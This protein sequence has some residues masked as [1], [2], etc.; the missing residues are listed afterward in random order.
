M[1]V[2]LALLAA[3]AFIV[4]AI[5][6]SGSPELD[7]AKRFAAAWQ[8]GDYGAMYAELNAGLEVGNLRRRVRRRLREGR[9]TATLEADRG[10]RGPR[11]GQTST[12]TEQVAVE[13]QAA[14][15]SFG[16]I[17]GELAIP[18]ADGGVTWRRTSSSPAC[19]T[20]E[21]LDRKTKAPKRAP[22]LA[23]DGSALAEGPAD[24]R[25]TNGAGGIVTGEIGEPSAAQ[26][27]ALE[28]RGFPEGT[29]AGTSGLE[30]AFD[31]QLAG[32]PGG[33]LLADLGLG[34]AGPRA[35]QADP[36][37][38]AEDDRSIRRSSRLPPTPSAASSAAS[39]CSTR[40]PATSARSPA[41]ASPRRSRRA[42]R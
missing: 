36:G 19:D 5:I 9:E 25:T 22:I 39:P 6:A 32:T 1:S 17:G 15:D 10:R 41:S 18:V 40:R 4:G 21:K 37:Q 26:A 29:K 30:L 13:L 31:E 35:T 23:A 11:P 14:T 7:S 24:A 28:A 33:K 38:A 34:Q 42:R 20:G 27:K 2:P 12:A 8:G 16:T 3:A